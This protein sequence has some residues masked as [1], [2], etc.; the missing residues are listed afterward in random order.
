ML[1][2]EAQLENLKALIEQAYDRANC[3]EQTNETSLVNYSL[4]LADQ[5]LL[6]ARLRHLEG[7]DKDCTLH[8]H[9]ARLRLGVALHHMD[10]PKAVSEKLSSPGSD[11]INALGEA[12]VEFKSVV[13]WK[14][15]ILEEDLQK[16]FVESVDLFEDA[17]NQL[18]FDDTKAAEATAVGG[19]LLHRHLRFVIE[20]ENGETFSPM[21]QK[22]YKLSLAALSIAA[23]IDSLRQVRHLM[24]RAG[25]ARR[26]FKERFSEEHSRME[27]AIFACISALV[28]RNERK[29]KRLS[30]DAH[31]QILTLRAL[32][33]ENLE[34]GEETSTSERE[35]VLDPVKFKELGNKLT[36]ALRGK[37]A[38]SEVLVLRLKALQST[39]EELYKKYQSCKPFASSDKFATAQFLLEKLRLLFG[40]ARLF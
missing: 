16:W 13:E 25:A 10:G 27:A 31:A 19:L 7:Q 14:N 30:V 20:D 26:L 9:V 24:L 32:L 5:A 35:Q 12:I 8:F 4:S 6:K 11:R 39:Y 29:L 21:R 28:D 3:S 18:R 22:G 17:L 36:S 40:Q 2:V 38:D 34:A 37:V 33:D 23:Q 1:G 15:L